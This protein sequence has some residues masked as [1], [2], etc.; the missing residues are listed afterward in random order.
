MQEA[1]HEQ[2]S[3]CNNLLMYCWH[4]ATYS[5]QASWFMQ[6]VGI[7]KPEILFLTYSID[8]SVRRWHSLL[9]CNLHLILGN[10]SISIRSSPIF[11]TIHCCRCNWNLTVCVCHSFTATSDDFGHEGIP[12]VTVLILLVPRRQGGEKCAPISLSFHADPCVCV[13]F[14]LMPPCIQHGS[15]AIL[16]HVVLAQAFQEQECL[17]DIISQ[18]PPSGKCYQP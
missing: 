3:H 10:P 11:H 15:S 9:L 17:D 12:A 16:S 13:C 18:L 2:V 1:A 8:M 5:N 7:S 6:N 4:S 14:L